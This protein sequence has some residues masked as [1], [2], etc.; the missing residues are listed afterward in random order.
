MSA[1]KHAADSVVASEDVGA[2]PSGRLSAEQAASVRRLGL[3]LAV[4]GLVAG[5]AGV[6][7]DKQRFAFA[8]LIGFVW[9]MTIGLGA[10]IFIAIQHVTRTSWSVA[11]RRPMEW[12][13]GILPIG[14]LLFVPVALFAPTLYVWMRH[15]GEEKFEGSKFEFWLTPKLFFLRAAIYFLVWTALQRFFRGESLKQDTSGDPAHTERMQHRSAPAILLLGLT[16]TFAGFDWLMSLQPHWFSTIFGIYIFSGAMTSSLSVLA[17]VTLA[18]QTRGL[19]GRVSTVEHRYD[20]G[21]MLFGF[22]IFWAYIGFSQYFLIWYANI[23]EET[24]FFKARWDVGAWKSI[25]LLLLFGHFFVPFLWLLSRTA[26]RNALLLGIGAVW[27]LF[28]HWVDMYWLVMPNL[29]GP[30]GRGGHLHWIDLAGLL[31][32]LGIGALWLASRAGQEP[33]YPL[34]DPR[35][36][37]TVRLDQP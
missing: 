8:Y 11:A 16:L 28:M 21:K 19:L 9:L 36:P 6:A 10:L 13:A 4:V 37:E 3:I 5:A 1:S 34:K 18:L 31:L 35:I 25:S 32:P 33:F 20:I 27:M 17:L 12:L 26:K 7:V 22:T 29:P 30:E 23:P 14:A 24:I 15:D 2:L